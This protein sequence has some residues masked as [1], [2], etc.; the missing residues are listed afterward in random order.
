ML[1]VESF[2]QSNRPFHWIVAVTVV[3][4][5]MPGC[6]RRPSSEEVSKNSTSL[7]PPTAH[8]IHPESP[9]LTK[10]VTIDASQPTIRWQF[11]ADEAIESTPVYSNG[12]VIFADVMG[13]IYAIDHTNGKEL[14]SV[15]YDTGFLAGPVIHN[16]SIVIGDVEG[17][18]FCLN[19]VDG[20][21][22]WKS[23]TG[24][25]IS[26]SP[27]FHWNNVL[28]TSQDGKL[29]SFRHSDGVLIWDYQTDDQIRCSPKVVDDRTFLGG[30]DGR[31]HVVNLNGGRADGKPMPLGGPTGSTP[32]VRDSI[33]IV[34]I[35]DG[36]IY[37]FDWESREQLWT[38]QDEERPQEYRSSPALSDDMVIVSSQ[39]K[40][41]DALSL[42][43]G[44]LVWR[45]TLRRRADA[46]PVIDGDDV[47]I[48]ATD[49]RLVRLDLATG[50]PRD[51]SF[52]SRGGFYAAPTIVGSDLLIA[53][54]NGLVY[55]ITI[56]G[57]DKERK[58]T[59]SND[60]RE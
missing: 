34:P 38:H 50:K 44:E 41:V 57:I 40:Q 33:V 22:R 36:I 48:A 31:L 37:A 13:K 42:E 11:Q 18:L 6:I 8:T 2:R 15:D 53:D 7:S 26:G 21:E 51:W 58:R 55:C 4:F 24:G 28:V 30:C 43:T 12:R 10:L 3:L 54:D 47:W 52:E 17:N 19:A 14:W 23:E 1:T 9:T 20:A 5:A 39:F 32:A 49:G 45:H 29:Y 16:T 60:D 59:G 25:E 27:V 35:M 46:S 56:T